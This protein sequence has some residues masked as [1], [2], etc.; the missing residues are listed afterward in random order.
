MALQSGD[1]TPRVPPQLWMLQSNWERSFGQVME[2]V[3]EGLLQRP[4]EYWTGTVLRRERQ[5]WVFHLRKA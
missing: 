3:S 1:L 4:V 5:A 2:V